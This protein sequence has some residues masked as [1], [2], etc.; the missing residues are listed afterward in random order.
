MVGY[1]LR[2][3]FQRVGNLKGALL[4]KDRRYS[5]RVG[6]FWASERL[7]VVSGLGPAV[8]VSLGQPRAAFTFYQSRDLL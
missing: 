3:Q 8:V 1:P 4:E 7:R 2:E 5:Q 6:A